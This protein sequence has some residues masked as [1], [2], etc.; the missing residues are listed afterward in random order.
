[1]A[2]ITKRALAASLKKLVGRMPL[3]K[4]TVTD[5]AEDC[6]VNRQ[7]FYYHFHDICD[8]VE[9]IY[10]KE[11]SQLLAGKTS[12]ETWQQGMQQIFNYLGENRTFVA[13]TYRSAWLGELSRYLDR[14]V[15]RLLSGIWME[16]AGQAPVNPDDRDFILCF[17]SHALTGLVLEWVEAGMR[18]PQTALAA[19]LETLL[20]GAFEV[21]LERFRTDR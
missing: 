18:E 17:Y 13:A 9:W 12:V 4:V 8:L 6:G 15:R 7:T 11:A 21:A 19:R 20:P 3:D 14:E 16:K 1:M 2:E 10:T 5:I